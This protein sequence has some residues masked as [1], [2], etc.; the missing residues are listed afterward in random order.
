M[1]FADHALN[2]DTNP[3]PCQNSFKKVQQSITLKPQTQGEMREKVKGSMEEI[4][5]YEQGDIWRE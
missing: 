5:N 4:P 2:P 3:K 1:S